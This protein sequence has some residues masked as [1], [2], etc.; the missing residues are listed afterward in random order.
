VAG[1]L[2]LAPAI[3]RT[4]RRIAP[5][6]GLRFG[7]S[8]FAILRRRGGFERTQQPVGRYFADGNQEL[9][10][11]RFGWLG[12]IADFSYELKRRRPNLFVRDWRIEVE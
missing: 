1:T 12:E 10:L 7:S 11:I 8:F 9:G 2:T 3:G 6:R 5:R 4:N